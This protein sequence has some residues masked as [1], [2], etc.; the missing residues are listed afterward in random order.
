MKTA[1]V[2]NEVGTGVVVRSTDVL[3]IEMLH[4]AKPNQKS[5]TRQAFRVVWMSRAQSREC[6]ILA[7]GMLMRGGLR[8][9]A[10]FLRSRARMTIFEVGWLH[11]SVVLQN[12]FFCDFA[13]F[14]F[15]KSDGPEDHGTRNL[16]TKRSGRSSCKRVAASRT[17]IFG[18][19]SFF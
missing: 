19:L 17:F 8:F 5:K 9:F 4:T 11:D 18:L 7:W 12:N 1:L 2:G 15:Q 14:F 13:T 6:G 3:S 16:T 10:G